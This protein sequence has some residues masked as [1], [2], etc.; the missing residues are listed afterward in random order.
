MMT[1]IRSSHFCS[2]TAEQELDYLY[3]Y[4][5]EESRIWRGGVGEKDGLRQKKLAER[6]RVYMILFGM[7]RIKTTCSIML[8][9]ATSSR[10]PRDLVGKPRA[11]QKKDVTVLR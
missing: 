10:L 4:L 7:E 9:L 2:C 8:I 6:W 1:Q 5:A 11:G 3:L